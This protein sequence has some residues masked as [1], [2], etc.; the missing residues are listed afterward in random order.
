MSLVRPLLPSRRRPR[1]LALRKRDG[2]GKTFERI[3]TGV[4]SSP[5]RIERLEKRFP[6]TVAVHISGHE[7]ASVVETTFTENVSSR[8]ACVPSVRAW[9][10]NETLI[11]ECLPGDFQARARVAYCRPYGEAYVIGIEFL[12]PTGRWVVNT[13]AVSGKPLQG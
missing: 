4:M 2:G 7:S 3:L 12:E 1:T 9:R 8:G 5:F 6:M 11:F 13:P 10:I